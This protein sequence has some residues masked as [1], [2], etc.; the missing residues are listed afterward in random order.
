MTSVYAEVIGDPIAHSKSPLIHN[1]WLNK[2]GIDAEYRATHVLPENLNSF[3]IERN[4]DDD[5]RGCNITIP[6][7]RSV[8]PFLDHLDSSASEVGAVNT[9]VLRDWY[10]WGYNTDAKGFLDPILPM[11]KADPTYRFASIIGSGGA[12]LAVAKALRDAGFTLILYNR[13][14]DAAWER[15]GSLCGDRD[16]NCDLS[17]LSKRPS[18]WDVDWKEG[19]D[20]LDLIVNATSLGMVGQPELKIDFRRFPPASVVYD[21]VYAPLQ[22]AFL[23]SAQNCGMRTIDGLQMLV[24]QAALAFELFFGQPAPRQHDAEL[25]ELLLA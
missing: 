6:H 11:L 9:V 1:F 19:P 17:E 18:R 2:L 15:L 13:D 16:L 10:L 25:R 12:A 20:R 4:G 14:P 8:L 23:R 21:L 7:K 5:W 3:L 22:T 24:G